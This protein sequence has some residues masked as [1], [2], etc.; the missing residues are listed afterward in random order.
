MS[1]ERRSRLSP[2]ERRAQLIAIGVRFLTEHP[3]DDLTI[4]ELALR[5][6]VSKALV[7][8]YF[9][10]RQGL[11]RAIVTTARDSLLLATEPRLDLPPRERI[12]DTLLR[13]SG[14]VRDHSGTFSSLVRGVASGDPA[15][16]AIVDESRELN[17]LRLREAFVELGVRDDVALRVALRAWVSF[18]EE[19]LLEL[20]VDRR[21]G[22]DAVVDFLERTLDG[23]VAAARDA[24]F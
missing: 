1:S 13:I 15:V 14:F 8:H 6:G 3:L 7:F 24:R 10:S 17:A 22:D 12:R 21:V 16:R 11:E 20:V 9:E 5:A 2:D 19:A 23:V 4:E 18:T